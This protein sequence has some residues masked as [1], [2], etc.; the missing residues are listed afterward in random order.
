MISVFKKKNL[1]NMVI[2]VLAVVILKI[3][4]DYNY[5]L[6][7]FVVEF[8][9]AMIGY[10]MIIITINTRRFS[11]DNMYTF[12]GIAF[13]F[14]GSIDLIHTI[15]YRGMNLTNITSANTATQLWII[16]RYVES[17]SLIIAIS[18][19]DK[20]VN[21]TRLIIGYSLILIYSIWVAFNKNLFPICYVDGFGLTKFKIISEYLISSILICTIYLTYKGRNK[22]NTIKCEYYNIVVC[23][24]FTI[25]SE[26]ACLS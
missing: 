25:L 7:H 22:F 21:F 13:A 26:V 23:L 16:A 6:F 5:L 24:I 10:I 20:K 18:R 15:V 17:I 3:I 4:S 19:G 2:I 11:K 14:I 9:T 12:L 8:V 1:L